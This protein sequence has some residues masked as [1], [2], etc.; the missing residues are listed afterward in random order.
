MT[1]TTY[2]VKGMTCGH[3]ASSVTEEVT[4]IPG[5]TGVE[6]DLATGRVTVGSDGPIDDVAV[7]AAVK[8]AGYEVVT[9]P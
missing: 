1:T 2:T 4:E 6:V 5:V 7:T 9:V 8:E 3:C